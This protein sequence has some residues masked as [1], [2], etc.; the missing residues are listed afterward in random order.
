[1]APGKIW[2]RLRALMNSSSEIHPFLWTMTSFINARI[3]GPPKPTAPTYKD[4]LFFSCI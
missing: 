3:A 1:M 4:D 2:E